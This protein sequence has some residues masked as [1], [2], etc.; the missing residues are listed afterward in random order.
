MK[1]N[2]LSI[3]VL[4]LAIIGMT[5]C[6]NNTYSGST[7]KASEVKQAQS[8]R[9]ATVLSVR[10]VEISSD[11]SA[12]NIG[13]IGGAVLGGFA[14]NTVGGGSGKL[15]ATA[16]GALLGGVVGNS[17][18][19]AVGKEKG[20][21]IL[22]RTDSGQDISIVQ[23]ADVNFYKGQKVKLIGNGGSVRVSP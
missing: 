4:T 8:V 15:L 16:G 7:Y 21:E 1:R 5:G 13:S 12:I 14:G 10:S 9:Y 3:S 2:I 18:N 17:A 19:K 22:V 11:D 23:S 20:L 6:A